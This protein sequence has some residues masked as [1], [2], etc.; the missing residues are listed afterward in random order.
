MKRAEYVNLPADAG[1]RWDARGT[2]IGR[3]LKDFVFALNV[4]GVQYQG[5]LEC[6]I[7]H[8]L[9]DSKSGW[10]MAV[11]VLLP[12]GRIGFDRA[13]FDRGFFLT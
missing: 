13:K 1:R 7:D 4:V 8:N 11:N 10:P 3:I 2:V 12:R 6:S 5:D 9:M